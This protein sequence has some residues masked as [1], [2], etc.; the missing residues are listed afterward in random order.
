MKIEVLH[1]K[2]STEPI[3]LK[4]IAENY[5]SLTEI[6][7]KGEVN[8]RAQVTPVVDKFWINGKIQGTMDCECP[9]C[10]SIL[11]C[12]F[13]V[14]LKILIDFF[15]KN[16]IQWAGDESLNFDEYSL[17]IG[18]NITEFSIIDQIREQILL[19]CNIMSP[20]WPRNYPHLCW[21]LLNLLSEE[22]RKLQG[23]CSP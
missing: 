18:P 2:N 19:N 15:N 10:T 12:F 6:G 14:D 23:R 5:P 21:H 8:F 7:L 13:S 11:S 20:S 9:R 22:L 17:E 16:E 1:L 4:I 3:V